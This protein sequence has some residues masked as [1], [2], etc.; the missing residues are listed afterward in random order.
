MVK[1]FYIEMIHCK[2]FFSFNEDEYR[3]FIKSKGF[4]GE[5]SELDGA[6]WADLKGNFY[7]GVFDNEMHTLAHECTHCALFIMEHITQD[8]RY[9]DEFLPYLIGLI[10]KKCSKE[11]YKTK[12]DLS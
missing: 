11:Y 4:N 5:F 2:L 7:I 10:F 9:N 8:L 12:K 6:T 3:K 1:K